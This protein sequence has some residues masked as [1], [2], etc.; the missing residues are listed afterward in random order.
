[1]TGDHELERYFVLPE[2]VRADRA[3]KLLAR[4][5]PEFSRSRWQKFFRESRVWADER[6]L[7]Q[8]A[9]L[10]AGDAVTLH[11][12]PPQPMRL[13][14]L[15]MPLEILYEDSSLLVLN[16]APGVVV[17]PG[18]GTGGD[19]LVHGLLH[20]C[21]GSLQSVGGTE[22]PGIVH[23]LDK[24]TSGALVVAKTEPAFI[25]LQEQFARREV[26]KTYLALVRGLPEAPSGSIH[27]PIRRHPVH[28]TL[29]ACRPGGRS[30]HTDY[31]VETSFASMASLLELVL[32][33][34][35]THQIRVHLKWLGYPILGD[36]AYGFRPDRWT[37]PAIPRVMLHARRLRFQHPVTGE[38][39]GFEAPLWNDFKTVV[40]SLESLPKTD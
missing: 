38:E 40:S 32:H 20:H 3:D 1:M 33:T 19:T 5:F 27:E 23:R 7:A 35:R 30:A 2:D 12:P 37:G 31:L 29:M 36:T 22:R 26:G 16:K 28:R 21:R 14:P 39:M 18:A 25:H 15:E 17:H 13:E 34:G 24:E 9:R 11:L 8:K 10:G 6:V 4:H